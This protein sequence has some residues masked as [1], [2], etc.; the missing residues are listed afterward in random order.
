[1]QNV[2]QH[3]MGPF[4]HAGLFVGG[5]NAGLGNDIAVLPASNVFFEGLT[6]EDDNVESSNDVLLR[7]LNEVQA[8]DS[9]DS[10]TPEA[11]TDES[12]TNQRFSVTEGGTGVMGGAKL[13]MEPTTIPAAATAAAAAAAAAAGACGFIVE[14]TASYSSLAG[15]PPP[16][17]PPPPV[18]GTPSLAPQSPFTACYS[19]IPQLTPTMATKP[20]PPSFAEAIATAHATPLSLPGR[21]TPS[22]ERSPIVAS[23]VPP[24]PAAPHETVLLRN[25]NGVFLL[26]P[27]SKPTPP[28]TPPAGT[29]SPP[30]SPLPRYSLP[31][32][33]AA[34]A[35]AA[36]TTTTT[37]LPSSTGGFLGAPLAP[38][39]ARASSL[40]EPPQYGGFN[41]S[42]STPFISSTA[43][44]AQ[45]VSS[46]RGTPSFAA[47]PPP[48]VGGG[49]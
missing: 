42:G 31:P 28:Y 19:G 44:Y 46:L 26:Q 15:L 39:G 36:A 27:A 38:S 10:T 32:A 18:Y 3:K 41:G 47:A 2:D 23:Y 4:A 1:M 48:Y 35:A 13:F 49:L 34:A 22:H 7:L 33:A 6:V 9:S 21:P 8:V 40:T 14:G 20:P 45:G 25:S 29:T 37:G 16:P 30:I 24:V 5:P 17:P 43:A 12:T 11:V